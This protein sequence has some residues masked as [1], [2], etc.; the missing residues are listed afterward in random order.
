MTAVSLSAHGLFGEKK[1][2]N[3]FSNLC[4]VQYILCWTLC[5]SDYSNSQRETIT[6]CEFPLL[7]EG[8]KNQTNIFF[9]ITEKELKNLKI[10]VVF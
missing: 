6:G 7:W 8:R 4:K 10:Q 9:L 3:L 5:P 2:I 1:I